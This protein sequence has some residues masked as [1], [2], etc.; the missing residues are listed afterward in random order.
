MIRLPLFAASVTYSAAWAYFG[1]RLAWQRGNLVLL[2]LA[3]I[4]SQKDCIN[5]FSWR[6]K[7]YWTDIFLSTKNVWVYQ[8]SNK[9]SSTQE[10]YLPVFF[11]VVIPMCRGP[12]VLCRAFGSKGT[13]REGKRDHFKLFMIL[14]CW[15]E[16]RRKGHSNSPASFYWCPFW[17]C[18]K[19]KREGERDAVDFG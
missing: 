6:A 5:D 10:A 17:H 1:S 8:P 3:C 9:K 12:G 4:L 16:R 18:S 14:S 13:M 7:Q 15:I 2:R 19:W 11:K